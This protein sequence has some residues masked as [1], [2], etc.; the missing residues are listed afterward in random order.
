[1]DEAERIV[2]T[3]IGKLALRSDGQAL[4]ALSWVGTGSASGTADRPDDPV[5]DAAEQQLA[6]WFAGR[7]AEFSIPV[8]PV[9]TPFQRR[10]WAAMQKVPFGA[11]VT[12]GA[13]ASTVGSAARGIGQACARNPIPIIIPCHRVIGSGRAA[14]GGYS[15]G[16]GLATKRWLLDHEQRHAGGSDTP[17]A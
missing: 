15:G 9:G 17:V 14:L 16:E 1:M 4:T 7:L 2:E 6:Q 8:A 5:L 12:Y 3:P 11:V 13:L 10:V